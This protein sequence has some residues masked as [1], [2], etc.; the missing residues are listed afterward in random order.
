VPTTESTKATI[1]DKSA[2]I[3]YFVFSDSVGF[4]TWWDLFHYVYKID[5][6]NENDPRIQ[7][8]IKYNAQDPATYTPHS[9][10]RLLLPPLGVITGEIPTTWNAGGTTSGSE[11]SA[12]TTIQNEVNSSIHLT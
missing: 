1:E 11:T 2:P 9:G 4:R 8:I 12:T 10:D 7:T 5:L 3:G 6:D